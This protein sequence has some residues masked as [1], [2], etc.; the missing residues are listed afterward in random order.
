MASTLEKI[1]HL[2][3][4][5]SKTYKVNFYAEAKLDD[6]RVIVTEDDAMAIGS[7][8]MVIGD[9]GTAIA[10]ASGTYA[11]ED[12]TKIVVD[13]NSTLTVYGEVEE[14]VVEEEL[15]EENGED[16]KEVKDATADE[17]GEAV[18]EAITE[19]AMVD[20]VA[21]AINDATGEEVTEEIAKEAAVAAVG[22]IEGEVPAVVEEVK[23]ELSNVELSSVVATLIEDKF[24][25]L[26]KRLKQVEDTPASEGINHNPIALKKRKI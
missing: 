14:E 16:D 21:N 15:Q 2:L 17:T 26:D 4:R 1:K 13:E 9:D 19:P 5:K 23:E 8:V 24:N 11:L 25:E 18:A 22:A 10:L 7:V 6:G 3:S 20:I 12:G